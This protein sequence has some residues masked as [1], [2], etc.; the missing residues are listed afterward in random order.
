MRNKNKLL[1]EQLDQKLALFGEASNI[2][3]PARG[4]INAIRTSLNMTMGQLATRLK[5][6]K[7]AIQ[8]IEAREAS[9]QI[10]LNKIIEVGNALEMKFVYGFAPKNGSLENLVNQRAEKIATNIVLRTHQNMR[11]EDQGI[12]DAKIAASIKELTEELKREMKKS[13]WD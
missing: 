7:G 5:I 11:L 9:R 13:L 8:K 10:S 1:L 3:V 2:N 4:W 6:S 12:S